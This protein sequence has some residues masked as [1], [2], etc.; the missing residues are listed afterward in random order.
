MPNTL[1]RTFSLR[2]TV[3]LLILA[4][5]YT[6][7]WGQARTINVAISVIPQP[8]EMKRNM[9]KFLID[10]NSRITLADPR[11]VADQF[12]AA[13]FVED[14]KQTAEVSL[15]F[16]RGHGRNRILIGLLS[17]PVIQSA[18]KSTAIILPASLNEEGYILSVESNGVVVAGAS[19]AGVFYGL[20][21]L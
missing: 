15:K 5:G 17:S 19:P 10:G 14:L 9:E 12:A 4:S 1:T 6:F 8:R 3:L 18:L 13:D 7:V 11:S 21:T 16:S 20:Q 2:L